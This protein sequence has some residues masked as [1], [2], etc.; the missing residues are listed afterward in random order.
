VVQWFRERDIPL[1]GI[2]EDPGQKGWT[3][4]PK[5]YANLYIDDAGLG[6]PLVFTNEMK[7]RGERAYVDWKKVSKIL[8][9]L[10]VWLEEIK[11]V[12]CA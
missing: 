11:S 2:N 1:Y 8:S 10:E 3:G 9:Q 5:V 6:M 7:A 12:E 4:S